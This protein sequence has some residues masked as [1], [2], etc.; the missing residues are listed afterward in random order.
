[1]SE[2]LLR[3]FRL[4]EID[5]VRLVCK[6]DDCG[7]IVEIPLKHL[8]Q[9]K[10][11]A[12]I[13]CGRPFEIAGAADDPDHWLKRFAEAAIAL[14]AAKKLKVEFVLPGKEVCKLDRKD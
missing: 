1:M 8:A 2:K 4:S 7:A 9:S 6:Q 10:Y 13:A 12:C 3:F 5:T 14:N 11:R